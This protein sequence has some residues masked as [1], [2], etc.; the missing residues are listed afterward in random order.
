MCISVIAVVALPLSLSSDTSAMHALR[1]LTT[2]SLTSIPHKR[3]LFVLSLPDFEAFFLEAFF[4]DTIRTRTR[5]PLATK[6]PT[7]FAVAPSLIG[8]RQTTPRAA[9]LSFRQP[10]ERHLHECTGHVGSSS[11]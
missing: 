1:V 5:W 9:T 8:P 3:A 11:W 2:P 6:N 7:V 10:V 4:G